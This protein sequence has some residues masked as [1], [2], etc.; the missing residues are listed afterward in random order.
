MASRSWWYFLAALLLFA[1][2]AALGASPDDIDVNVETRGS[3][4]II[5]VEVPMSVSPEEAWPT[6]TDYDSMSQ[7]LPNLTESRVLSRDGNNLR[8]MQKGRATKGVLSFS[9]ENVRDVV[10]T[11]PDEIRTRLVSGTIKAA[12]SVTR[13]ER[14]SNGMR[15]VN[16]GEYTVSEFLPVSL[17]VSSI[18]NETRD[19]FARMRAEV[20]RRHARVA[21]ARE[22]S[23]D[24]SGMR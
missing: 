17:V 3:T 22:R 14:T 1:P 12:N 6:L 10:L 9:F 13:L 18:A 4:V 16:H 23:S 24:Q 8:V 11:P 7:F 19:N 20:V 5:D 2:L 15:L 21:S